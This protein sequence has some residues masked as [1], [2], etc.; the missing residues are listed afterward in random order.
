M[1]NNQEELYA[2]LF[3]YRFSL[4]DENDNEND[5]SNEN[6]NENDNNEREIIKKLKL[7]LIE[8]GYQREELTS[9]LS[10][11]YRFYGIEVNEETI[12]EVRVYVF[13]FNTALTNELNLMNTHNPAFSL[14]ISRINEFIN[15]NSN[16]N[17]V[18]E[19]VKIT[20]EESAVEQLPLIKI[21]E[22]ATCSICMEDLKIDTDATKLNC[23][24]L[25]HPECI[26]SY[27]LNYDYKCPL[28]RSDVGNHKFT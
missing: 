24:H 2:D 3:A 5:N 9:I 8:L 16:L 11:F 6:D 13:N 21:M 20:V 7:K 4:L 19:D 25:Y 15:S 14:L 17:E 28:C 18:Q 12:D 1:D 23:N 26:K 10:N 27:L 22:T